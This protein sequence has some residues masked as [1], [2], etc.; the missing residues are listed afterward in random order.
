[1]AIATDVIQQIPTR[2]EK[3]EKI[4]GLTHTVIYTAIV[5]SEK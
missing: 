1:M 2:S 4:T 3:A 5:K